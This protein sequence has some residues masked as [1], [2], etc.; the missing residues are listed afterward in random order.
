M[1]IGSEPH[2][3]YCQGPDGCSESGISLSMPHIDIAEAEDHSQKSPSEV[4]DQS[5]VDQF[6]YTRPFPCTGGDQVLQA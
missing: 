3:S 1:G 5:E 2:Q 6:G 4:T